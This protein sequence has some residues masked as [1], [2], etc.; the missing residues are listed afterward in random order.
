ADPADVAVLPLRWSTLGDPQPHPG[1]RGTEGE[2]G[3]TDLSALVD[4]LRTAAEQEAVEPV[5]S[6][7]LP[8]L[9][10]SVQLDDLGPTAGGEG[11]VL[12]YGLLDQP[13]RQ[14]Q[15]TAGWDLAAD[16]PLAVVGGTRSGRTTLL[17]ALL[18]S[19]ARAG[20]AWAYVL[21][22]GAG[23]RAAADLPAVGAVVE[24]DDTERT[25]RV[26]DHLR[27]LVD[28]R[29]QGGPAD[30]P[31]VVLVVDGWDAVQTA[32][33]EAGALRA[34]DALLHVLRQGPAVRV[35]TVLSGGRQ[36]L[37]GQV[38][39]ALP[40][41]L[42]LRTADTGDAVMAGVPGRAVPATWPPGRALRVGDDGVG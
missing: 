41:R 12:A 17:R 37:A 28:R 7:W 36:L 5:P 33:E 20:G 38:G 39:S 25:L 34:T 6:P 26:L 14:R 32:C 21:D 10:A 19:L 2:G 15:G 42:V 29:Q 11:P 4:A 24:R 13:S 1:A 27:D 9:P 30:Q 3:R 31:W 22:G 40:S 16:G 35:L 18:A 23:L 8:P